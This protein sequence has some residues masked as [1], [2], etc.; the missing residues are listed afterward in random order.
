MASHLPKS[1]CSEQVSLPGGWVS[2]HGGGLE[3]A[4]GLGGLGAGPLEGLGKLEGLGVLGGLGEPG[5][6]GGSSGVC[7]TVTHGARSQVLE[8]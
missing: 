6:L 5:G 2:V 1:F 3:E 7:V 8:Q 4:G